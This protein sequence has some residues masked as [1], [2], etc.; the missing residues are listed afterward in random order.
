MK[1]DLW[2]Y[3]EHPPIQDNSGPPPVLPLMLTK[4]E[5]QKLRR[6]RRILKRNGYGNIFRVGWEGGI[7]RGERGERDKSMRE[8]MLFMLKELTRIGLEIQKDKQE[9]VLLGIDPPPPPK[10]RVSQNNIYF[11]LHFILFFVH[12]CI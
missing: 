4:K 2:Q 3:V 7:E 9:R 10:V 12:K 1:H 6:G 11:S 8:V 5:L